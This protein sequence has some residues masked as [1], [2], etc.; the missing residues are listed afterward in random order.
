M[1]S[2]KLNFDEEKLIEGFIRTMVED[3]WEEEFIGKCIA[4]LI[5]ILDLIKEKKL[6]E[7]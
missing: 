5:Y 2:Q 7:E 6:F 4:K 1:T 3:G